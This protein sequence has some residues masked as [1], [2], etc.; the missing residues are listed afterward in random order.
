MFSS[1]KIPEGTVYY[2]IIKLEYYKSR[3]FLQRDGDKKK[4]RLAKWSIIYRHKEHRGLG[5]LDLEIENKIF[6]S[7]WLYKLI[8]EERACQ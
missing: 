1:F 5:I 2:S 4:Y 8:N 6:L 3:F 7:K